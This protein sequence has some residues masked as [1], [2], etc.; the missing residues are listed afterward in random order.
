MKVLLKAAISAGLTVVVF[1]STA[2]Y[3]RAMVQ[4]NAKKHVC[5]EP[6]AETLAS[7]ANTCGAS[8]NQCVVDVKRTGSSVSVTP[9][10]QNAKRNPLFSVAVGT[11][12]TWESTQKDTG[13]V[14]DFGSSSPF[15]RTAIIG[16]A[17]RSVSVVATKPGC[18]RY[19]AGACAAGAIDGMCNS[20][21]VELVVTAA[22]K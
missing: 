11:T 13:F 10:I 1:A 22:G 7:P 8:G 18:Y 20:A 6:N 19:R 4:Q 5:T 14:I 9:T 21:D 12:V 15:D 17:D 2:G 3:L 16:G